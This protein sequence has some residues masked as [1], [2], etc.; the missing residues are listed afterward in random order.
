[1]KQRWVLWLNRGRSR[2]VLWFVIVYIGLDIFNWLLATCRVQI[3]IRIGSVPGLFI[4]ALRAHRS[5]YAFDIPSHSGD[6]T[7][8]VIVLRNTMDEGADDKYLSDEDA[9]CTDGT[10]HVREVQKERHIGRRPTGEDDDTC[11]Y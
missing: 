9:S 2:L 11:S 10:G 7:V 5:S 1:M 8:D 4:S 3:H 6:K